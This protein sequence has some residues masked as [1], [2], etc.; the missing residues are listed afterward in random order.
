MGAELCPPC[1]HSQGPG[2][3]PCRP[4][5]CCLAVG[6]RG[7]LTLGPGQRPSI[8]HHD[9]SWR[10]AGPF[11]RGSRAVGCQCLCSAHGAGLRPSHSTASSLWVPGGEWQD[12]DHRETSPNP[13]CAEFRI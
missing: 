8:S 1:H 6:T 11:L 10:E 2:A 12:A 9:P 4:L 13:S 5:V 7:C 3:P